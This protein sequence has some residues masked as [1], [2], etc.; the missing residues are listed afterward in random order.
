MIVPLLILKAIL[1]KKRYL[2]PIS[3][4]RE[5][6]GKRLPGGRFRL[7]EEPKKHCLEK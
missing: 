4:R 6:G 3:L 2:S 7:K 1:A 5:C